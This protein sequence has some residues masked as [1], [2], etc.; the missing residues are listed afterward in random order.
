MS[1]LNAADIIHILKDSRPK[2]WNGEAENW[3]ELDSIGL[4][5]EHK[6][7]LGKIVVVESKEPASGW[8]VF[9]VVWYFADNNVYIKGQV[10]EGSYGVGYKL[11][12]WDL[13]E[14]FPKK[15]EVT[16]YE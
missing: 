5:D 16:I 2:E 11:E 13:K 1:K 8:G 9:D 6:K 12:T 15:I 4:S 14:V 7:T 10:E 3:T